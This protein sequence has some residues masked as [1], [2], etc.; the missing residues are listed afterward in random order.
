MWGQRTRPSV[1]G[2]AP[3][4]AR[5]VVTHH[6]WCDSPRACLGAEHDERDDQPGCSDD[7]Q[8]DPDGFGG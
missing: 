5:G 3:L 6:R 1:I 2:R 8:D 7:H 4:R